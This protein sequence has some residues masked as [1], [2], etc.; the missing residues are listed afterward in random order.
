MTSKRTRSNMA[1]VAFTT[2]ER[3]QLE[4][5]AAERGITISTWM[6]LQIRDEHSKLRARRAAEV[7]STPGAK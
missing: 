4:E 7:L 3:Q 2:E 1:H 5:L 6:R